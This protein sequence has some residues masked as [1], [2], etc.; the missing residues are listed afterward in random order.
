[1]RLRAGDFARWVLA[2]GTREKPPDRIKPLRLTNAT[3][4]L[5]IAIM[6][7][8]SLVESVGGNLDTVVLEL[9]LAAGF[10]SCLLM[11]GL[12]WTRAGRI[13]LILVAD[14]T[15]F[16]GAVMF[17]GDSGG[18]LP[19]LSMVAVPLLLFV[20]S[21]KWLL[22]SSALVAVA[23]FVLCETGVA[24]RALG[25]V[26]EPAPSWYFAANATTAFVMS[27]VVP[28]L[29]YRYNRKAEADLERA[30]Q[31]R[32]NRIIDSSIIGIARGRL[33]EPVRAANQA[34]LGL[35]GFTR[36]DLAAGRIDMEQLTPPEYR[37]KSTLAYRAL[38]E[39]GVCPAFEKEYFRKD[40]TRIPVLVGMALLNPTETNGELVG[41]LLDLTANKHMEHQDEMLRQS[42]EAVRVRELFN[43]IASHELRTPLTALTLQIELAIR[44]LEKDEG[45]GEQALRGMQACRNSARKLGVLINTLLD[46]TKITQA[47]LDLAV[48]EVD[49]AQLARTVVNGFEVGGLCPSGQIMVAAPTPVVGQWDAVRIEQVITN[50]LSNAIKY[51]AGKPI[52][53]RVDGD[54]ARARLEISDHG[55]G[56]D[57]GVISR[58]FEPFRRAAT[59]QHIQGLGLGLY[60]ARSIVE[61][62]GGRIDVESERDRGSRFSVEL[63]CCRA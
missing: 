33:S 59:V 29:F 4:V 22:G 42:Q 60:V 58:I 45:G 9:A 3:A 34:F 55:I 57:S 49:L 30:G 41:F 62:H 47:K 35:L 36:E 48:S 46:V 56:I 39:R 6:A 1:M 63:P 19:F 44:T 18:S 32:L 10:A 11:N 17:D 13:G 12:G 26:P 2:L 15:I 24:T 31:E 20:S 23:L 7:V 53:M 40:G 61:S 43:S 8:W 52:D 50:L 37:E 27:F 28:L 51:G 38:R 5:G 25:I 14:G 54:G 16:I 21:E